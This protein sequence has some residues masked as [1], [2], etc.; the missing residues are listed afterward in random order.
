MVDVAR[1]VPE[2]VC[3]RPVQGAGQSAISVTSVRD[4]GRYTPP[5]AAQYPAMT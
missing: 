3:R 4:G 2:A 5:S 1:V